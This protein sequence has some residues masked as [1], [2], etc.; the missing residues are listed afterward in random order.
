MII[1]TGKK[2]KA[3]SISIG[4]GYK[5]RTTSPNLNKLSLRNEFARDTVS[6]Q[7]IIA[8]AYTFYQMSIIIISKM[9][10]LYGL[11]HKIQIIV[12]D[13]RIYSFLI[14]GKLG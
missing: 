8:R 9:P 10:L 14:V 7:I 6:D 2:S 5:L 3:N 11:D 13:F 1:I 12:S 4:N